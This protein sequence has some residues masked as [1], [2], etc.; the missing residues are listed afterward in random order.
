MWWIIIKF[1][2]FYMHSQ[3]TNICKLSHWKKYISL[4]NFIFM[5]SAVNAVNLILN[6][7]NSVRCDIYQ[8]IPKWQLFRQILCYLFIFFKC[9]P[10]LNKI[11]F[12][13]KEL[14]FIMIWKYW[15]RACIYISNALLS[16]L[17]LC[18]FKM[19]EYLKLTL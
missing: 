5:L 17:C 1:Y 19:I 10:L 7:S 2:I 9:D 16:I 3:H 6:T 18:F 4:I 13:I 14:N 11:Y 8:T 12:F 15:R